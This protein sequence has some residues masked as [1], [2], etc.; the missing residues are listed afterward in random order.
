MTEVMPHHR[1]TD[2]ERRSPGGVQSKQRAPTALAQEALRHLDSLHHF[3][4]HLTGSA[5]A[6]EDLVQDTYARALAAESSFVPDT[7][8]RAWLFRILRNLFIDGVRRSG[9]S[10]L[11]DESAEEKAAE[12]AAYAQEPLRGDAEMEALRGVVAV[13][14]ERALASLSPDARA[15]ILLDLEGC[16]ETEVAEILGCA[17]GTVKSRLG[18]AREALRHRLERYRR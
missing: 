7:N 9:S 17:L 2:A 12:F 16:T 4:C 14:I 13:D 1:D 15:V 6:A 3:A 5:V 8:L 10:P 18:R 11:V